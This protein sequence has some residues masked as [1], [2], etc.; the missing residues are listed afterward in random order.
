M[1]SVYFGY[2]PK[3]A[4]NAEVNL[5]VTEIFLTEVVSP[6]PFWYQYSVTLL[7]YTFFSTN[8]NNESVYFGF[9]KKLID[10][11]CQ[12]KKKKLLKKEK[13]NNYGNPIW[14]AQSF[15]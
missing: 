11:F 2:V 15:F 4:K 13:I 5:K 10:I 6:F 12:H 8:E 7:L 1:I 9:L 3:S 14:M